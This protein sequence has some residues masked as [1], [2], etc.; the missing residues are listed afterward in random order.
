MKN[1]IP[2][3]KFCPKCDPGLQK[4]LVYLQTD[5]FCPDCNATLSLEDIYKRNGAMLDGKYRLDALIGKGGMGQV[6]YGYH[7]TV[8]RFVAIKI[9]T[10]PPNTPLETR[11]KITELFETEAKALARMNHK[12]IVTVFEAGQTSDGIYY[13][14]Q[15]WVEGVTLEQFIVQ[16]QPFE[17]KH[18]AN[19]FNQIAFAVDEAHENA[20]IHRDLKPENIKVVTKANGDEQIKVLDFGI[21]KIIDG[22]TQLMGSATG[23]VVV[24][25]PKYMSP[26]QCFAGS[27]VS[28]RSDIYSLGV[29]LYELFTGELPCKIGTG[30]N[31]P[32]DWYQQKMKPQSIRTLR[33]DVPIEVEKLINSMLEIDAN[34]RPAKAGDVADLLNA[35]ILITPI[36]IPM[37]TPNP[38]KPPKPW[39]GT[40][41]ISVVVLLGMCFLVYYF[42]LPPPPPPPPPRYTWNLGTTWSKDLPILSEDVKKMADEIRV[43]SNGQLIIK[44]F[45][46]GEATDS[47]NNVIQPFSLFDAISNNE[48]Q[49][50]HSASYYWQEK[51]PAAVFFA[52]VPFGMNYEQMN[53]WLTSSDGLELWKELYEGYG[54]IPFPCGNSGPQMGGWFNKEIKTT[55]DFRGL[56]MRIP[57]LGGKVIEKEGATAINL[58]Q[59]QI[60]NQANLGHID[61]AEWIGPYHDYVMELYK[62]GRFYYE[63]GWQ[64]PNVMFELIIN[65]Q[66]F[67]SL[68]LDLQEI[69]RSKAQAYNGIIS[70][71]FVAKN[72][73]YRWK[74]KEKNILFR[75][76]PEEVLR[77]LKMDTKNILA[78]YVSNDKSG[79][80]EKIYNSYQRYLA[81]KK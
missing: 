77:K 23:S 20:I 50:V 51:V 65:K 57:G 58:P 27:T 14:V 38:P 8:D 36:P 59:S 70:T 24:G 26:E 29:I 63:P 1:Q 10:I 7:K 66:A 54:L 17:L 37:P 52:A 30:I 61:A 64:E 73:E 74:L 9:L 44:V 32:N 11:K 71:E 49:M 75:Q 56:R 69:I 19:L 47:K 43:M 42:Y 76:F 25:T 22:A 4:G 28:V 2:R 79:K 60:L 12:N 35:A 13:I 67:E 62:M 34:K 15:E 21:S 45:N 81:E 41:A 16:N 80:S 33:P 78:A 40:I 5:T 68:P 72:K 48:V 39:G 3:N 18:V 53:D 46:A 6:Y 31:S 55:V